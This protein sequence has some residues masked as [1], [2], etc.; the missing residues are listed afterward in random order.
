MIFR[1]QETFL[2]NVEKSLLGN[3]LLKAFMNNALQIHLLYNV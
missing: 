3:T 2:I 1:N